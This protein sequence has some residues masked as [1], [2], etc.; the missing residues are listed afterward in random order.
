MYQ[1][2]VTTAGL[3]TAIM[4]LGSVLL[5]GEEVL[6]RFTLA[7]LKIRKNKLL[8]EHSKAKILEVLFALSEPGEIEDLFK[9]VS[10]L[11]PMR[12]TWNLLVGSHKVSQV[13]LCE[14]SQLGSFRLLI[15]PIDPLQQLE[16]DKIPRSTVSEN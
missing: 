14:G 1:I 2:F 10:K 5:E 3:G 16:A 15:P 12:E 13:A 6:L 4:I 8:H 9:Q 7:I 11:K